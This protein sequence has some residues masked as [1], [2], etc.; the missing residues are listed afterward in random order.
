MAYYKKN[1]KNV[2]HDIAIPS[3]D[4]RQN[5]SASNRRRSSNNLL[6]KVTDECYH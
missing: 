3:G 2:E 5:R 6:E 4:A 1:R